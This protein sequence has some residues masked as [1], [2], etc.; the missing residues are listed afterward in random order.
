MVV[1]V[2]VLVDEKG[3]GKREGRMGEGGFL[4]S[5]KS[6]SFFV[7][8]PDSD[9]TDAGDAVVNVLRIQLKV[10]AANKKAAFMVVDRVVDVQPMVLIPRARVKLR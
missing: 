7:N 1:V 9:D 6:F 10:K 3:K 4:T 2:V 5:T 8:L